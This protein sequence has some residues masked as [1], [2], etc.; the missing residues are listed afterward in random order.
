V[1]SGITFATPLHTL[2]YRNASARFV[3]SKRT[4]SSLVSKVKAKVQ[5]FEQTRYAE[6]FTLFFLLHMAYGPAPPSCLRG[7]RGPQHLRCFH[8]FVPFAHVC[9][10]TLQEF[11][12]PLFLW[13]WHWH[14]HGPRHRLRCSAPFACARPTRATGVLRTQTRSEHSSAG[15]ASEHSSER[16]QSRCDIVRSAPVV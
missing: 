4:F 13:L 5:E 16:K 2:A 11:P 15:S 9:A 3:A 1:A 10:N 6:I 8:T 12:Q 14:W 7:L